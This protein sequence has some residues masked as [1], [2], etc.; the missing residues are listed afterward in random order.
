MN[1]RLLPQQLDDGRMAFLPGKTL[2]GVAVD[3]R[4]LRVE[5]TIGCKILN[6]M[7]GLWMPDSQ[8]LG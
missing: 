4:I 7:T 6:T 2:R 3:V 8:M 1:G 5:A